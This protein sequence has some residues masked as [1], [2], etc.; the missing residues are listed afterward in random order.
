MKTPHIL[1][2]VLFCFI[3]G[4]VQAQDKTAKA[5]LAPKI[6]ESETAT[7]LNSKK[8]EFIANTMLPMGQPSKNLVGSNYSVVF[9]PDEII[10]NM[11]F[12]GR[13]YSAFA[14][15]KDKGMRF[16]GAPEE[17][18]IEMQGN[19]STVTARVQDDSEIYTL[20]LTVKKSGY[21]TL[22]IKNR[23]KEAINY[24][25]EVVQIAE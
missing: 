24:H 5:Q 10:S 7:I 25:G 21:A 11:P 2:T 20:L 15:G 23:N 19:T 1:F 17:F 6:K 22:T 14:M 13:S 4:G 18:T 3:L 8:F 12:Y 9:T 16:K